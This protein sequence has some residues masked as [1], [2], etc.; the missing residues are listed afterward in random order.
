M[1]PRRRQRNDALLA[2]APELAIVALVERAI[3][4]LDIAIRNEHP[5]LGDLHRPDD[6]PSLRA[7]RSLLRRAERTRPAIRAYAL[8]VR[9]ALALDPVD[10]LPF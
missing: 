4:L 3:E 2:A 10:D 5:T 1:S 8:A 6:P 9:R 7:A